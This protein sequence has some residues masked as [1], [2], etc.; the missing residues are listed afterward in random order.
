MRLNIRL[1][2]ER[3]AWLPLNH[4][5]LLTGLIYRLLG[6]SDA[7]YTRFLHDEGYAMPG[8]GAKRFKLFTFSLL[9]V[10]KWRRCVEGD[11][12]RI[13]PGPVDW[14]LS[15]PLDDFLTHSATGLFAVSQIVQVGTMPLTIAEIRALPDPAFTSPMRFTCL[16][17]LVASVPRDDG[18]TEYLRPTDG[19]KFSAAICRNLQ[20]KYELLYGGPSEGEVALAFDEAY[21]ARDR[22][23][24]TKLTTFKGIQIRGA[25]APLTLTG[26]AELMEVA[27]NCG[28]GEKN[29][30]GFGMVEVPTKGVE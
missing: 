9:R 6:L 7:D 3:E 30:I 8:E 20:R 12:L 28:L 19:D 11:R 5:E 27:W 17:P 1:M 2:L 29:S 15:S 23:A 14:L 22:H 16:T 13:A 4:N 26:P 10:P 18:S 21:L 24:G 25:F